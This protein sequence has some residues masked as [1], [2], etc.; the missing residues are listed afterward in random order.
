MQKWLMCLIFS[1][2]ASISQAIQCK[3][4]NG[5]AAAKA[6]CLITIHEQIDSIICKIICK[7]HSSCS[8]CINGLGMKQYAKLCKPFDDLLEVNLEKFQIPL[9]F[10]HT[11]C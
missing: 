3:K 6:S 9:W 1:N 8:P 4:K 7:C 5:L 10:D 11:T 2:A